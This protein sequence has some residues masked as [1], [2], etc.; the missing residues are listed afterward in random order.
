MIQRQQFRRLF[1]PVRIGTMVLKNRI[2]LLPHATNFATEDGFVTER[3][4]N[5][6]AHRAREV[7]LVIVE[8]GCVDTPIGKGVVRELHLDDDK[9]ISG[10]RE[11]VQVI[12]DNGAKISFQLHHAGPNSS[13]HPLVAASAIP[14]SPFNPTPKELAV[15]EIQDIVLRYVKAA[16]RVRK[17]GADAL[18][19]VAS[20]GY[21]LWSFLSPLWNKRQDE[22]G[23]DLKGRV[24]LLIEIIQAIRESLGR[25]YPMTIRLAVGELG[26]EEGMTVEESQ[27]VA[28]MSQDAGI[29]AITM[30]AIGY[31]ADALTV[32]PSMRGQLLPLAEALKKAVNI[33]VISAGRMDL[34]LGENAI[35]EGKAD[36]VGICRRLIADPGYVGKAASGRLEDIIP[37]IACLKGCAGRVVVGTDSLRCQVNPV[38]GREGEYGPITAA[39]KPKRIIVV[40][41]GPGGMEVAI[42][43]AQRGHEVTLYEKELKLGGQLLL[44]SIPPGKD[45]I[46]PLT[47]YLT[48]QVDKFCIQVELEKEVTPEMVEAAKPD[49]VVLATGGIPILPEIPG[50]DEANVTLFKDVLT[51]KVEVGER[52]II[53]G[54]EAVGCETAEFLVEKGKNVTIVEILPNLLVKE[55]VLGMLYLDRLAQKGVTMLAGVRNQEFRDSC[56]TLTTKEGEQKTIEA[57]TIVV[58]AGSKQNTDLLEALKGCVPEIYCVGDCIEAGDIYGAINEGYS[59]GR[60]I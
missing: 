16:E 35:E 41:G 38:S 11:L 28:R 43:A 3:L 42:T 33:P 23:G 32:A 60:R 9:Y 39:E 56:L 50:M 55:G 4:K 15:N 19:V 17:A 48:A 30:T 1:E 25:T 26:T 57:D 13:G 49:A 46:A 44:A 18:E 31:G 22:Y 40:G 58:A 5:Y 10:L 34:E 7:G 59:I 14:Y 52:V 51:G 8:I 20:G 54:G 47:D 24:R 27:Q 53:I 45:R 21:L 37:C 29:D 2:V 12:H 6:L 36:L